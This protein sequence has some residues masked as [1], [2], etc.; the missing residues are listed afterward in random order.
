MSTYGC[1]DEQYLL[2]NGTFP[3]HTRQYKHTN[4]C[5][6]FKIVVDLNL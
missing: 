5:F 1:L 2:I 4:S 3:P 6:F